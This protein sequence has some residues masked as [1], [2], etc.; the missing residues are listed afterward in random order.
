MHRVHIAII[1]AAATISSASPVL[2]QGASQ[3]GN[4]VLTTRRRFARAS[5]PAIRLVM[6]RANR[7]WSTAPFFP[8]NSNE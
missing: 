8:R 1:L 2:S 3:P 4:L 5:M 7:A 6:L